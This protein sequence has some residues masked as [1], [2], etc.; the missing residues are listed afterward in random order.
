MR[1]LRTFALFVLML[2]LPS[3]GDSPSAPSIPV[4]PDTVGRVCVA[5][6]TTACFLSNRFSAQIEWWTDPNNR[7]MATVTSSF[8]IGVTTG[9]DFLLD[10]DGPVDVFVLMDDIC[11]PHGAFSVSY[12]SETEVAFTLTVVDGVAGVRREYHQEFGE[13]IPNTLDI[14]AFVTCS[15]ASPASERR[16]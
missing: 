11:V 13:T 8:D 10:G 14:R 15:G 16:N 2:A 4:S 9:A 6:P 1:L 3:C 7:H 12:T 5:G